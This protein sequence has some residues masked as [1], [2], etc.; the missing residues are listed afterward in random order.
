MPRLVGTS[1]LRKEHRFSNSDFDSTLDQQKW[2]RNRIRPAKKGINKWP[3][4]MTCQKWII[5]KWYLGMALGL[6]Y[7]F[8]RITNWSKTQKK[9]T[10]KYTHRIPHTMYY[11][12]LKRT[13]TINMPEVILI[14][15]NSIIEKQ[16][17]HTQHIWP[18]QISF[19]FPHHEHYI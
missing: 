11:P 9:S 2:C 17:N 15:S 8:T 16:G 14:K 6:L 10:S 5:S 12:S 19:W 13:M 1:I 4:P 18:Y 7:T 3:L